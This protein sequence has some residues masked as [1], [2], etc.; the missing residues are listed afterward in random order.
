MADRGVTSIELTQQN[1]VELPET[2]LQMTFLEHVDFS[3]NKLIRLPSSLGQL[4]NLL[5]LTL[6][7]NCLTTAMIPSAAIFPSLQLLDTLD[8][9]HNNLETIPFALASLRSLQYLNLSHNRLKDLPPGAFNLI[10]N[11]N[12]LALLKGTGIGRDRA[13]SLAKLHSSSSVTSTP[14]SESEA[15]GTPRHHDPDLFVQIHDPCNLK[16]LDLRHNQLGNVNADLTLMQFSLEK[17]LLSNNKLLSLPPSL[18]DLSALKVLDLDSN[19]LTRLPDSFGT[20]LVSLQSLYLHNNPD[21]V[22]PPAEVVMSG[23]V[24]DVLGYLR[25]NPVSSED[26][27]SAKLGRRQ[28]RHL[29][30]TDPHTT[31]ADMTSF[32]E[33]HYERAGLKSPE[34]RSPNL[35]SFTDLKVIL[36]TLPTEDSRGNLVPPNA[37]RR[38]RVDDITLAPATSLSSSVSSPENR[39]MLTNSRSFTQQS[40][41]NVL[42]ASNPEMVEGDMIVINSPTEVRERSASSGGVR[43]KSSLLLVD[44][45]TTAAL[46]STTTLRASKGDSKEGSNDWHVEAPNKNILPSD[47]YSSVN[48]QLQSHG[49]HA[50]YEAVFYDSPHVNLFGQHSTIGP[51]LVSVSTELE[52]SDNSASD[53]LPSVLR[54][55]IRTPEAD[56]PLTVDTSRI[57]SAKSGSRV[58]LRKNLCTKDIISLVKKAYPAVQD[59]D[60][61][62]LDPNGSSSRFLEL[63]KK[64]VMKCLKIGVLLAQP[65]Q[66]TENEYF[67]NVKGSFD[68]DFFLDMFG[69]R[70]ELRRWPRYAGGLDTKR[71][72]TGIRSLYATHQGLEIMFHVST[73]LPYTPGCE[74]QVSRK[75][76]LGNDIVIIVFIEGNDVFDPHCMKSHFNH[77]FVVVRVHSKNRMG[78][79]FYRVDVVTKDG[80]AH[81]LPSMPDPP[82]FEHGEQFRTFLLTKLINLE[83]AAYQAPSFARKL[84]RTRWA[85]FDAVNTECKSTRSGTPR[86]VHRLAGGSRPIMKRGRSKVK[87][88]TKGAATSSTMKDEVKYYQL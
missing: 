6:S 65:G 22:Y 60:I 62:A 28:L 80:V 88:V 18:S 74:Q 4:S 68:W 87:L 27:I 13:D 52:T 5:T 24:D 64:L 86:A 57:S 34:P 70:V 30:D 9:S 45:T 14:P 31:S 48:V 75:R 40:T 25:D 29:K 37:L 35:E 21:L 10:P 26:M 17:L 3:Q 81:S 78:K 11:M 53:A 59:A 1:L 55:F 38:P 41:S 32:L 8:L 12:A 49:M 84:K 33:S 71:D 76:H 77:V 20:G 73:M 47:I 19:F 85:L 42:R 44:S 83:R 61:H 69:E 16:V 51:F 15:N 36:Q 63:E 46:D 58:A 66:T 72:S 7:H 50:D 39:P 82:V 43:T 54:V 2:L 23:A 67:Q 56:V 79:A